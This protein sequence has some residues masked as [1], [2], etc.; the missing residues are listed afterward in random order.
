M[1][2]F[3]TDSMQSWIFNIIVELFIMFTKYLYIDGKFRQ[4]RA[5]MKCRRKTFWKEI[6]LQS[7]S[8][9]CKQSIC[10]ETETLY[11][12]IQTSKRTSEN[13][14]I[15][16]HQSSLTNRHRGWKRAQYL[17]GKWNFTQP[18]RNAAKIRRGFFRT[19]FFVPCFSLSIVFVR[20]DATWNINFSYY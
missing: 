18:K 8:F 20:V 19:H 16:W 13:L 11:V 12:S 14:L 4:K 15:V 1:I 5:K 9:L 10:T 17:G 6:N 2:T 7:T 3:I